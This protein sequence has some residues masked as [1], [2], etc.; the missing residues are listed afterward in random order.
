MNRIGIKL[1]GFFLGI[2]LVSTVL[3]F[4]AV[5]LLSHQVADEVALDQLEIARAIQA[6]RTRTELTLDDILAIISS[7][8]YNVR[9]VEV[10][11]P[12]TI[13]PEEL[14]RL[15][16]DEIVHLRRGPLHGATTILRFGDAFISIGLEPQ[17][18]LVQIWFSRLW[19]TILLYVGISAAL[20]F[21]LANRVVHPVLQLTEATQ[22]VA[23]GDF[24]VRLE[25]GRRNDEIGRLMRNFDHMV[26]ELR[27]IE[28]LRKDFISSV[29]H[30]LK[31]PLAAIQGFAQLLQDDRLSHEERA[32]Y[33]AT[34]VAESGR[35]ARMSATMLSLSRLENQERVG[36]SAPFSL[37]EQIRRTIVLLEPQWEKKGIAMVVDLEPVEIVGNEELLQQA[38][39][40]LLGNAIKFTHPGG[41]ISVRSRI[42]D[43]A[44]DQGASS[45]QVRIQDNGIGIKQEDLERIFDKFFQADRTRAVEGSGLGLSLVKRI[46]AMFSGT[47]T[48]ESEPDRGTVFVVTVPI[49]TGAAR[50]EGPAGS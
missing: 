32:D 44:P 43:P 35:L 14:E 27:T 21:A 34:I 23:R 50:A 37:D 19:N 1:A 9:R 31:T 17:R 33:A 18:S 29:S 2:I 7:P 3:S 22:R 41:E 48:V 28:Y 15:Q 45:V 36:D 38:W 26:R 25:A 20:I 13:P 24:D 10:L 40:N 11:D 8:N 16:S 49:K 47:I 4:M 6:L 30:E 39:L 46:V 5:S 42:T 12:T